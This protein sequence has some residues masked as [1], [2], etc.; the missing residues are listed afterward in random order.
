MESLREKNAQNILKQTKWR[1][2]NQKKN[3][4]VH[5]QTKIKFGEIQRK[6]CQNILNQ[7][8]LQN[9]LKQKKTQNTF[10]KKCW[11]NF[12]EKTVK[13][14]KKKWRTLWK[15]KKNGATFK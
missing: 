15:Q 14:L 8:K 7:E 6:K 9:N 2:N 5:F 11:E 12:E 1:K 13:N 3:V 10:F 4:R